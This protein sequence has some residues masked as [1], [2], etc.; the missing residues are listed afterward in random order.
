MESPAPAGL[1]PE[2]IKLLISEMEE[3]L[4]AID[5]DGGW[6]IRGRHRDLLRTVQTRLPHRCGVVSRCRF[7]SELFPQGTLRAR[8]C[9]RPVLKGGSM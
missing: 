5:L 1:R 3:L 2:E 8:R 6:S 7:L 4:V 9:V